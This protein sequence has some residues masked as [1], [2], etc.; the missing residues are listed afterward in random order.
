MIRQHL[1]QQ[2]PADPTAFRWR[3]KDVSRLE[4]FSDAV[5]G[6][7]LTLLVVS[8]E[9]P[10]N[11]SELVQTMQGFAGF[12]V[13]FCLISFIW[14]DHYVFFR[15]YGLNDTLTV[16]LNLILL[17]VVM[18]YVYPLKFLFT[19][20]ASLSM[21]S[22]PTVGGK[23]AIE[24]HQF[25]TLLIIYGAGFVAVYGVLTL[26]YLNA[27]RQRAALAFNDLELFDTKAQ[28]GSCLVLI[29]I[30]LIS[31]GLAWRGTPRSVFAAGMIYWAIGLAMGTYWPIAGRRRRRLE[32]RHRTLPALPAPAG[33]VPATV[34]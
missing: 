6:F 32:D 26:M 28:L 20:L 4:G 22:T 17:F 34:D 25:P 3:G 29:T 18:F 31:I 21:G 27:L 23:P 15:Q 33:A 8:L 24:N 1:L 19:L 13:C 16:V 5:F 7:A 30:G 12:A 10:K 2:V 14:Y 11:F 9:V